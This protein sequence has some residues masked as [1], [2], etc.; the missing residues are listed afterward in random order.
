M[1]EKFW[2]YL[3]ADPIFCKPKHRMD[4]RALRKLNFIRAIRMTHFDALDYSIHFADV[5]GM[6]Y[7]IICQL[8]DGSVA[9]KL[10]VWH[11]FFRSS[12]Y[13]LGSDEQRA[14]I[15][16]RMFANEIKGCVAMT[17]VGHGTNV[18]RLQTHATYDVQSE[19]FYIHSP[20]FSAAKCWVGNLAW[21]A[22][23]ATVYAQL[24]LPSGVCE[25]VHAFLIPIRHPTTGAAYP[26]LIIGDMGDKEGMNGL[27][28]GFMMFNNYWVP[29]SC[30][31]SRI[32]SVSSSGEY[33][34]LIADPNIRF[35]ASLIP[36]FTGRWSVLGFAWANLLKAL[37]IAIRYSAVRKQFGE[38]GRGQE[39]SII[40]YQTQQVRIIPY[41]AALFV[42]KVSLWTS[43]HALGK[44]YE[45]LE[46]PDDDCSELITEWHA[47]MS[48]LKPLMT[49]LTVAAVQECREACGGHGYLYAAGLSELKADTDSLVTLEGDNNV[50][51]QQ[52][53]KFLLYMYKTHCI[54]NSTTSKLETPMN[55]IHYIN[56]PDEK[57]TLKTK[58]DI[59]VPNFLSIYSFLVRYLV[60]KS[61]STYESKLRNGLD[62]FSAHNESQV[63][64]ARTLA[65]VY[66]ERYVIEQYW[67]HITTSR[68]SP[69]VKLVMTE[70]CLLYSAW[71]LEK[72]VPYLYESGYFTE[73]Q[74]VKL[75]QDTILRLCRHLKP[76]IVSLI[77]V[78]APPDSIV[79]SVLGSST[80]AV[81]KQLQAAFNGYPGNFEQDEE[82]GEMLGK[83]HL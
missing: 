18:K 74:P 35:S 2:E 50:L 16:P 8:Y 77:E 5:L 31:L 51:S 46:Q 76:N 79:D 3:A 1:K 27:D 39:M 62:K 60:R 66:T 30:L 59:S 25:G 33:S 81:Y 42:Y 71:S 38:D 48:G 65:L 41:V 55:S 68:M 14:D 37:L 73:G 6:N 28:N 56:E 69:P 20:D 7:I 40:E 70:L 83:S 57:V 4:S 75:I 23:H 72:Y 24:I 52:A 44:I 58:Q 36:L 26:G 13:G 45:T 53:S 17:E 54:G 61:I 19:G 32:S 80:G 29:R 9:V 67:L 34:S 10:G 82:W 21:S 22:T 12:V 63:F 49:W 47:L 64:A 43:T 15:L 78:E 11:G